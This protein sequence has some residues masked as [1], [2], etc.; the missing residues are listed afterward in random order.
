MLRGGK[1]ANDFV[2]INIKRLHP[3]LDWPCE[4]GNSVWMAL[5]FQ[6]D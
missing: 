6:A 1:I 2:Q 3:A 4:L 5:D